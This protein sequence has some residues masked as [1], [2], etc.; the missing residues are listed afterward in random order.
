MVKG[1]KRSLFPMLCCAILII[2]VLSCNLPTEER[3]YMQVVSIL[4]AS[5]GPNQPV[6]VT[7]SVLGKQV[8]VATGTVTIDGDT[9]CSFLLVDGKGNCQV[10][11]FSA[12]DRMLS[13]NYSGD[14]NYRTEYLQLSYHVDGA[15]T[16]TPNLYSTLL[17]SEVTESASAPGE[18]FEFFVIM[19]PEADVPPS[20]AVTLTTD[21]ETGCTIYLSGGEGRCSIQ[22]NSPGLKTIEANYPATGQ[23]MSS[24]A[25]TTHM[26]NY[27]TEISLTFSP[28]S[29]TVGQLVQ[30]SAVVS[31]TGSSLTPIG[32]ITIVASNTESCGELT[33]V[34]G[35]ASCTFSFGTAGERIV[36]A[37][38][39]PI[40]SMGVPYTD[41]FRE[42]KSNPS[43]TVRLASAPPPSPT[44]ATGDSG[45]AVGCDVYDS[46]TDSWSCVAPCPYSPPPPHTCTP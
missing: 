37:I 24:T 40:D 1:K 41:V 15:L 36:E 12:G 23:W 39:Y 33:L 7:V 10:V 6:T 13:I 45:G 5:T 16:P 30:V 11:F 27:P 19:N 22:F 8:G 9:H 18:S 2:T 31:A 44:Q 4:P 3:Q 46:A 20:G 26:V 28:V 32:V 42:S 38:Y 21:G 35:S 34:N 17:V 43:L 29:P 14:S 25:T